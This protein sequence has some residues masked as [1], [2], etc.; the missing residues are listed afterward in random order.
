ML[1]HVLCVVLLGHRTQLAPFDLPIEP[2]PQANFPTNTPPTPP[3]RLAMA[4][5]PDGGNKKRKAAM[6]EEIPSLLAG[7]PPPPDPAK[8]M[9]I[10]YWQSKSP[11][12]PQAP[13]NRPPPTP[14]PAT[15]PLQTPPQQTLQPSETLSVSPPLDPTL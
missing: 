12:S 9:D 2:E 11:P 13:A 8:F 10:G 14:P 1:S 6:G 4:N 3:A 7:P 15:L 5:D